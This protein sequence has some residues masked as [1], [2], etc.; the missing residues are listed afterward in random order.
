MRLRLSAPIATL[1][2]MLLAS[3]ASMPAARDAGATYLLVRH[4]EKDVAAGKDPPLT[5]IGAARAQRLAASLADQPLDAIYSSA[6]RRTRQTAEPVA[7]AKAQEV[8]AYDPTD[9]AAFAR[10]LR[11]EHPAGTVLVIGHSDTLPPLARALCAC[12]VAD[13]DEGNYGIRYRVHFDAGGHA[14]LREFR[15]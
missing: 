15:D 4:A 14:S 3:C 7:R 13:M 10:R 8:I 11:A 12:A 5:A 9:A 6:T 1:A 2:C